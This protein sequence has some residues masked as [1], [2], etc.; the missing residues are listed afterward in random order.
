MKP[1]PTS[2]MQRAMASGR[3]SMRTPSASRTS[4]EPDRPVA[5]RLPCL[6]TAQP[7]PA[8]IR[9]AVVDTLKVGLPPPVPAVSIRSSRPAST[10]VANARIVVAR[11]TSSS[12]VSPLVRSATRM[13]EVSISDALPAMISASTS[14]VCSAERFL[15][16]IRA[17]SAGVRTGLGI[18][19]KV[20]Q[21]LLS[22][23]R[24]HR[25]GVELDADRRERAVAHRHQHAAAVGGRLQLVREVV[26]DD[27]RVVARDRQRARQ[28]GEDPLAIVGDRGRLAVDRLVADDLAA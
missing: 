25:L 13:P 1:K 6:A 22:V 3:R 8:A 11:P 5:E 7:W 10:G 21:Q 24:E 14:A 4:A 28:P 19:Q 17:S 2:L 16:A 15:R 26:V 27:E 18:S 9:A 12:I 23:R 20:A